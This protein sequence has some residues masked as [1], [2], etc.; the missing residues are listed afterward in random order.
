[1]ASSTQKCVQIFYN[2]LVDEE[3]LVEIFGPLNGNEWTRGRKEWEFDAADRQGKVMIK[4]WGF[5]KTIHIIH[6]RP[7][8]DNL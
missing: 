3:R 2:A 7:E 8:S 4:V 1:M 5:Q 6:K